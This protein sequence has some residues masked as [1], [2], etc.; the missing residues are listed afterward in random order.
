MSDHKVT[1]FEQKV[2][3]TIKKIPKGKIT[4]YKLV[5]IA[6]GKPKSYRAVG[7]ALKN[8]PFAPTVPCHR[9]LPSDYKIGGFFGATVV[10]SSNVQKKI[11]LLK[12]EG[13]EFNLNNNEV[14][15]DS[16][17]RNRITFDFNGNN[18]VF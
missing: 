12:S 2:Y 6:M 8:N 13:I 14:K 4:T 17:Y 11:K 18:K 16:K 10:E 3:D 1:E 5:A 9:V 15:N 7:T